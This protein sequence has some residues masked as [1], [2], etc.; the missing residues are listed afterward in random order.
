MKT[1][2]QRTI[3]WTLTIVGALALAC[4][5]T[6]AAQTLRNEYIAKANHIGKN[7]VAVTCINGADPTGQKVG[8]NVLLVSCGQ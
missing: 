2:R 5:N 7:V 4:M 6:G 1:H 8:Q 3:A